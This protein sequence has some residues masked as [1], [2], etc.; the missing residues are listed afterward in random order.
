MNEL[1]RYGSE[2][3]DGPIYQEGPAPRLISRRLYN[4]VLC[5]LVLL[6]FMV[7]AGCSY[8]T[9]TPAF[10]LFMLRSPFALTL[11]SLVGSIAGIVCMNIARSRERLGLG[12]VGYALFSVTFGF[13]TSFLLSMYSLES[14]S[15]AFTATAA[16][17]VVFGVAGMAFPKF[18]A[19]LQGVCV[20]GLFAVIVVELIMSLIGIQQNMTDLVVILLFCGFIGYDVYRASVATPTFNNALWYA[21]ELYLDILNV[22][23]R[24]LSIVG[25]RD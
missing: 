18:F 7:M 9:A 5:G 3:Y 13:T 19:K 8:I 24:I 25:R 20:T 10:L 11:G 12:L 2:R 21:I 6:S 14:I 1:E 22:F 23:I 15:T 16:I 17:M 4:A